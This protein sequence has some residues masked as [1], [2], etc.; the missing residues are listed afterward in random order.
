MHILSLYTELLY[1]F[2]VLLSLET[3]QI[4]GYET[5]A[6]ITGGF[7]ATA[8][9]KGNVGFVNELVEN[10]DKLNR[11]LLFGHTVQNQMFVAFR[12]IVIGMESV[13]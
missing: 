4:Y 8:R 3:S 5:P 7:K 9:S 10:F 12:E 6:P 11:C 13:V 2:S 1:M